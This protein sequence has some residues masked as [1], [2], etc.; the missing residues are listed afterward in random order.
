M[1]TY[2]GSTLEIIRCKKDNI[3]KKTISDGFID[4]ELQDVNLEILELINKTGGIL[5]KDLTDNSNLNFAKVKKELD[6]MIEYQ[7]IYCIKI[8]KD[9][10]ENKFVYCLDYWGTIM[11]EHL[12]KQCNENFS[13]N[14]YIK[15]FKA[16]SMH[17]KDNIQKNHLHLSI[18]QKEKKYSKYINLIEFNTNQ[19]QSKVFYTTSYDLFEQDNDFK[20]W[21]EKLDKPK[22]VICMYKETKQKIKETSINIY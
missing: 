10:Y 15:L 9:G 20:K 17:Y 7:L 1:K 6:K 13:D 11:I 5:V 2:E 19:G 21:F 16:Y 22:V 4:L 12:G 3:T 18:D 14:V 8:N